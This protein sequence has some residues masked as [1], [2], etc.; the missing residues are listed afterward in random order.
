MKLRAFSAVLLLLF[1]TLG[2]G[3][4]KDKADEITITGKWMLKGSETME[5]YNGTNHYSSDPPS[6]GAYLEF[7]ADGTLF[8]TST[9][10][11]ASGTWSK[12]GDKLTLTTTGGTPELWTIKKLG[13]LELTLFYTD[14]GAYPTDYV[15]ITVYCNR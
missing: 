15:E 9:T 14:K 2:S 12:A 13:S 1:A 7:K 11:F 3:C 10:S 4:K 8:A 6:A 5:F